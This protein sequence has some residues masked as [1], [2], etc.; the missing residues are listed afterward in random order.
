MLY[1]LFPYVIWWQSAEAAL[2]VAAQQQHN[3][4]GEALK[5]TQT[6]GG[7]IQH[8]KWTLF[9]LDKTRKSYCLKESLR[10][11]LFV[12]EK[13]NKRRKMF[14]IMSPPGVS[15]QLAT[16]LTGDIQ[17]PTFV[18]V[19]AITDVKIGKTLWLSVSFQNTITNY[20]L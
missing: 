8:K 2:A 9:S 1:G 3:K 17:C 5:G 7:G 13:S 15:D 12:F 18:V 14:A 19:V 4:H 16:T 11:T 6:G 20:N 10:L